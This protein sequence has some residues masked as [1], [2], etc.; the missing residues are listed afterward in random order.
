MFTIENHGS[1]VLVRPLTAACQEWLEENTDGQWFGN[2]LVVEPRYVHD[3]VG[4]LWADGFQTREFA[5]SF[6]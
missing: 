4:G 6:A 1:L 2:A 5:E 3:L